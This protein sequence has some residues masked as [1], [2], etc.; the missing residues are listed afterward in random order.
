LSKRKT[1]AEFIQQA[2]EIH[3]DKYDYSLVDY[4]NN[5]TKVKIKCKVCGNIFEQVPSSHINRKY[6]CPFCSKCHIHSTTEFINKAKEIHGDKYDYSLVDYKNNR[7][8][9]KIICPEH[10]VFEQTP[11]NHL[12]GNKCP[13]CANIKTK[14]TKKLSIEE[15]IKRAKTIHNDKYDYS[16]VK[17]INSNTKVE[18]ICP[19]HGS[20]WQTPA[21]H[22]RLKQNC[23]HCKNKWKGEESIYH[24]LNNHGFKQNKDFIREKTFDDLRGKANCPLRYDF[25]ILSKNLL[26]EYNGS[27][28]YKPT[29]FFKDDMGAFEERKNRDLKKKEYAKNNNINLLIISYKELNNLEAI[30]EEQILS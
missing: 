15:F 16:K 2:K 29:K 28:H 14:E 5:S 7:I 4:K 22:N 12:C 25:Y 13:K 24:W 9:V 1:T 26:I 20:F 23:P 10:G 30:L 27:Q 11:H 8:K 17:Y 18:I 19:I 3:G 21:A 6:N